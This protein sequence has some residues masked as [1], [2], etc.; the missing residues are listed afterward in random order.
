[1][2]GKILTSQQLVFRS[3][4]IV[5]GISITVMTLVLFF[6]YNRKHVRFVRIF[7]ALETIDGNFKQT[8]NITNATMIMVVTFT[9]VTALASY[10]TVNTFMVSKLINLNQEHMHSAIL[11]GFM[12]SMI[13]S[14]CVFLVHFSHINQSIAS[15][16]TRVTFKMERVVIRNHFR[17][18]MPYQILNSESGSGGATSSTEGIPALIRDYWLLC[19]TVHE[20]NAFYGDQL[21][22]VVLTT[23]IC[24]V[25]NLSSIVVIY[26]NHLTGSIYAGTWSFVHILYLL[27][28]AYLCTNVTESADEMTHSVLKLINMDIDEELREQVTFILYFLHYGFS[29]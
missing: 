20:A 28:L 1:M 29:E 14:Q 13:W 7:D 25:I 15:R 9:V 26:S 18:L 4:V 6:S 5:K 24:T 3:L 23:L 22:A 2:A 21:L 11:Q 12:V 8:S 19:D 17:S 16:F 27:T 10:S